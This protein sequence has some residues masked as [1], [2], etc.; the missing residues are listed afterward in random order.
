VKWE[1]THDDPRRSFLAY[2]GG[3]RQLDMRRAS[4]EKIEQNR[5]S[6]G[7]RHR[8]RRFIG[9]RPRLRRHGKG[10][11]PIACQSWWHR[12]CGEALAISVPAGE[13]R[14]LKYFQERM[15]YGLFVPDTP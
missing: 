3:S 14:V 15:P 1:P 5:K 9:G 8:P 13:T 7:P 4:A 2:P 6:V 11:H 12:R 10:D